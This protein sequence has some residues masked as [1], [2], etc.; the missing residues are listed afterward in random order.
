MK[1]SK[2]KETVLFVCIRLLYNLYAHI[3]GGNDCNFDTICILY[4]CVPNVL[5]SVIN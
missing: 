1:N 4:M 2:S 3:G 5:I